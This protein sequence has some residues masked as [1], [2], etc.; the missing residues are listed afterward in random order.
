MSDLKR[1]EV[2]YI[3]DGAKSAY[4]KD[5]E[6]YICGTNEELQLHHFHTVTLM[7]ENWKRKNKIIIETA[8]DI[9][10]VRDSFVLEHYKEMY[11]EVVTLCKFHHMERLH[12]IYGKVPLLLTAKKQK[13]WCEKRREKEYKK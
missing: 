2:K 10:N 7:W 8:E 11:E 6:C 1:L 13:I 3:R 5:T 12:K 4:K 9:M